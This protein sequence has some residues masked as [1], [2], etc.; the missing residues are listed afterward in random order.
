MDS[1][2]SHVQAGKSRRRSFA[3]GRYRGGIARQVAINIQLT[4][5]KSNQWPLTIQQQGWCLSSYRQ[6]L[7]ASSRLTDRCFHDN[8]EQNYMGTCCFWRFFVSW[9]SAVS[10]MNDVI[11]WYAWINGDW[12]IF[13]SQVRRWY[14]SQHGLAEGGNQFW[15]A[16]CSPV[17]CGTVSR[18]CF[19]A[20][21]NGKK[22]IKH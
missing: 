16:A 9:S 21:V 22:V 17:Q 5:Q 19:S 20:D 15:E 14:F 6:L 13:P 12:V 4:I 18:L 8:E 1:L 3:T 10:S 2:K 7:R 11:Y